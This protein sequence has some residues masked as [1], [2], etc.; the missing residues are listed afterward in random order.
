MRQFPQ[1]VAL[2]CALAGR[3]SGLEA[4]RGSDKALISGAWRMISLEAG[5][6]DGKLE[7]V[8]Y[9]GQIVFTEAGTMSV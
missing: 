3:R 1:I 8:S 2:A 4:E 9:S 6:A 7:K 5:P